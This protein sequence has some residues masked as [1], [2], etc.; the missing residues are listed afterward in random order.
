MIFFGLNRVTVLDREKTNHLMKD[1]VFASKLAFH[2][3]DDYYKWDNNKQVDS[4]LYPRAG[5]GCGYWAQYLE[6]KAENLDVQ[7]LA[8]TRVDSMELSDGRVSR[9]KLSRETFS[10]SPK[11]VFWSAPPALANYA[12]GCK[13]AVPRPNLLTTT[14]YHL[15]YN[16]ELLLKNVEYFWNWDIEHKIFRVTIYPNIDSDSSAP[17]LTVEVLSPGESKIIPSVEEINEELIEMG[18]V[19]SSAKIVWCQSN[20]LKNTFPV[21]NKNLQLSMKFQHKK[22]AS[23]AN[24]S[25]VGRYGARKWLLNDVLVD[26]YK[27]VNEICANN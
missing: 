4:Y 26:A 13:A 8:N 7:L 18:V 23:I 15:C 10:R 21:P 24:L 27:K 5:R 11:H 22:I 20:T 14:L 6:R 16:R 9:V 12:M 17:R 2:N 1:P 3:L 25:L 19:A